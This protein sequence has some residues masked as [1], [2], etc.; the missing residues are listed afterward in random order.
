MVFLRTL[1]QTNVGQSASITFRMSLFEDEITKDSFIYKKYKEKIIQFPL[2]EGQ[3]LH[4]DDYLAEDGI[5]QEGKTPVFD[6]T[7]KW[8]YYNNGNVRVFYTD[9]LRGLIKNEKYLCSH[10]KNGNYNSNNNVIF[11]NQDG[12]IHIRID[13]I[14][15]V[16]EFKTF[17]AEQYTNG[18]P[19][20]IKCKCE[21]ETIIPYTKEQKEAYKN[22]CLMYEGYNKLVC[23]DEIKPNLK[24]EYYYNN[25]LNKSYT[26]R[27]DN[28]EEKIEKL[29]DNYSTEERIVGTWTN[30]K[31][32]YEKTIFDTCPVVT[33][34]G[35]TSFKFIDVSDDI[36]TSFIKEGYFKYRMRGSETR[37]PMPIFPIIDDSGKYYRVYLVHNKLVVETNA[38]NYNPLD[39]CAVVRYTK[40]KD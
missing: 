39:F 1:L 32:L 38:V 12:R 2:S 23:T 31:P 5:H 16:D 18:T 15:S 22:I 3:I 25:D 33:T 17:L 27:F 20:T 10:F 14:V 9:L 28:V 13:N 8:V 6:G 21:N 7:E 26:N 11:I 35:K 29:E 40:T 30:G 19:V 4:E 37:Q 36:D 24:C 34:E